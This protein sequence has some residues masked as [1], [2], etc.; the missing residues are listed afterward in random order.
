MKII[1]LKI[2]KQYTADFFV[3]IIFCFLGFIF[4]E[5]PDLKLSSSQKKLFYSE[6]EIKISEIKRHKLE[7]ND[8]MNRNLFAVDGSYGNKIKNLSK[9]SYTLIGVVISGK[10]KRAILRDFIG[11][12][13]IAKEKEKMID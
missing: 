13:F 7:I 10:E 1:E 5:K 8:I 11:R 2:L 3:L 9:N 6:K 4:S 12:I